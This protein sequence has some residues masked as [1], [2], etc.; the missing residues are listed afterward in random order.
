MAKK[1]HKEVH[2]WTTAQSWI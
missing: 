2:S 1:C